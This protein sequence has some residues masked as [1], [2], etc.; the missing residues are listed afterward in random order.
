MLTAPLV[1]IVGSVIGSFLNVCIQRMPQSE[2]VVFP[3][4]YCPKC[5]KSI[6]WY[7]NIPFLS[8]LFL[9]GR[10]R[11][12]H[13]PI[14]F[15][16]FLVEFLTA[17]S[18]LMLYLRFGLTGHFFIYAAWFGSLLVA[19]F[20]DLKHQIIPDEISLGGLVVG[21]GV[22]V[23]YPFLHGSPSR[24]FSLWD[25]AIGSLVGGGAIYLIGL[26]GNFVFKKESMGGG[27]VKLLAMVGS[28][29]GWKLTLLA[30]FIAPF[31]GSVVGIIL[32]I[33]RGAEVIPYGPFLSLGSIVALFWGDQ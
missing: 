8:Y 6:F 23:L 19:S 5:K 18:F 13:E 7:D 26:F 31:F 21:L 30:F 2:S 14:S 25:A 22:S 33:R 27:D 11:F 16:Y 1:F 9:K 4:S 15:Q 28:I 29:L 3:R 24:W 10:C 12:C 17:F 20:I 32:K